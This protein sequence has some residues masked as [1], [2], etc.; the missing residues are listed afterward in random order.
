MADVVVGNDD[1]ALGVEELRKRIIPQGIFRHAV[2]DLQNADGLHVGGVPLHGM[3]LRSPVR[4]R[5]I[6]FFAIFHSILAL[7]ML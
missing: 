5:K 1:K 2:G 6:K 3:D 4:G 7:R